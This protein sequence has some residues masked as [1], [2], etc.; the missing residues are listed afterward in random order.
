MVEEDYTSISSR[1]RL[2]AFTAP[3]CSTGVTNARLTTPGRVALAVIGDE[4]TL[5][6]ERCPCGRGLPLLIRVHG[7]RRTMFRLT[8]GRLKHSSGLVHAISLVGGHHQHQVVQ[9]TLEHVIVRIVPTKAGSAD[10]SQQL[11]RAVQEFFE[12]PIQIDLEIK[13]RL[14]P[15]SR[16]KL[17]SMICEAP[18]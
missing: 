17:Q 15:P 7:K 2:R 8:G 11:H 18:H 13:E 1:L 6:P 10:H 12:A 4:V 5:G 14:E 9:K 16:G 3:V